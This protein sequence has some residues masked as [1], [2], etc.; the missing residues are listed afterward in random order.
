MCLFTMWVFAVFISLMNGY[1]STCLTYGILFFECY[2]RLSCLQ[3]EP[4]LVRRVMAFLSYRGRFLFVTGWSLRL[5]HTC[6]SRVS[7]FTP[8][9]TLDDGWMGF[10]AAP[11]IH[12]SVSVWIQLHLHIFYVPHHISMHLLYITSPSHIQSLWGG[13]WH[14]GFCRKSD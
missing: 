6:Y 8:T 12:I 2:P 13:H 4:T 9:T 5:Y 14:Y 10:L 7:W 11:V 3:V 1:L